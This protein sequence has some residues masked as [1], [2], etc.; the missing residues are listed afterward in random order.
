MQR[1]QQQKQEEMAVKNDE[2]TRLRKELGDAKD[3]ID[4]RRVMDSPAK[5]ND[6]KRQGPAF[7]LRMATRHSENIKEI[8]NEHAAE[9]VRLNM[10]H[11][12][13]VA[14]AITK[15]EARVLADV[16]RQFDHSNK[17]LAEYKLTESKIGALKHTITKQAA[18]LQKI[19][20]DCDERMRK[21][22]HSHAKETSTILEKLRKSGDQ[23]HA[24]SQ[25]LS[26]VR[27]ELAAKTE[28][29]TTLKGQITELEGI[30]KSQQSTLNSERAARSAREASLLK[31]IADD[32][33]I[34]ET[35]VN[36]ANERNQ[37]VIQIY[38]TEL[39]KRN[40]TIDKL[41]AKVAKL[42]QIVKD[43]T[44]KIANLKSQNAALKSEMSRWIGKFKEEHF[45]AKRYRKE[46][47]RCLDKVEKRNHEYSLL[48]S[49]F[50][51]IMG[52]MERL[53]EE[54]SS[55][56]DTIDV[57]NDTLAKRRLIYSRLDQEVRN[58]HVRINNNES[59]A[60]DLAAAFGNDVDAFKSKL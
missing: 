8:R 45:T 13:A 17:I 28:V 19:S 44:A 49:N 11:R 39:D 9:I 18:Q 34:Y 32:R 58:Q 52:E 23:K 3:L 30:V 37:Q 27:D 35:H 22:C 36:E 55:L 20:H 12:K 51:K 15:T 2:M 47:S 50:R 57:Q 31:T 43:K 42:Q 53:R 25:R 7:N 60:R 38:C 48:Q 26:D 4:L 56:L 40:L 24:L 46:F 16:H 41:D 10:E 1:E 6:L 33:V 21:L 5:N 29:V 59:Y 54:K 14:E